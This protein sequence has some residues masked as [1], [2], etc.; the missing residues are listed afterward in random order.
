MIIYTG[1][2]IWIFLLYAFDNAGIIDLS[3]RIEA[4]HLIAFLA[5]FYLV[6]FIGLRSAGADT[7][8]YLANYNNIEPGFDKA[9]SMLYNFQKE[10]NLFAAYGIL[11]KT[12][13]GNNYTP[14]LFGIASFSGLAVSKVLYKYSENYYLSMFF[15]VLW[16]TWSWMYN[17][18]RQF[19]AV[20]IVFLC[21]SLIQNNNPF[22]YVIGVLIAS[23]IHTSA[24]MML[25]VYFIVNGEPWRRKTIIPV[26]LTAFAIIFT[27][28]FLGA[29]G[30][31]TEGMDYGE[32][33]N[34]YYFSTDTGS[35][36][37]RTI[38]FAIPTVLAFMNRDTIEKEAP[39]IIK[40]CVNMSLLCV[41]VSAIANVTSGIYIGR[42]PIYFSIYNMI[43]YPWLFCNTEIKERKGWIPLI[44]MFYGAYYVFENY[45]HGRPY[46]YSE[47][48]GL[49]LF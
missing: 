4:S 33:L 28:P 37:I 42:L 17:G 19:W 8:A 12:L 35:N 6:F 27:A 20:S 32:V 43:L 24:L 48:L 49:K 14:Y 13:F 41:C 18:I 3:D 25:P 5:M 47:I 2:L 22:L 30:S 1:A 23:R 34:G 38:V 39:D 16:G 31:V 7:S 36:P 15:F 46:Y 9:I 44:M 29:L 21:L 45:I 11:V 26:V 10:E 40:I